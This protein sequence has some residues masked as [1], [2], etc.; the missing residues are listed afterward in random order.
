MKIFAHRG[1][2]GRFPENTM[3]A[4]SEAVKAGADGIELDVHQSKDGKLVIIHDEALGRTT[5][6]E[7]LVNDYP[8]AELCA[9]NAGKTFEDRF[10][11]TPIP[12][13]EEYCDFICKTDIVTNVEIKTNLNCYERIEEDVLKMISRYHLE[14]RVVISSFNWLSVMRMKQLCPAMPCGLLHEGPPMKG[15]GK[16]ASLVKIE[17]YHP[18]FELLS[19]EIV[20]DCHENSI[21]LNV[22]TVNREEQFKKLIAWGASSA[23]TNFP[24]LGLSLLPHA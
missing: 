19:D 17:Y 10:G 16:L 15:I 21:G 12:S 4:F 23:I 24:D 14:D 1:F 11:R 5:G 22:W 9:M 18:G 3:L 6:R 13:F 20:A 8:L 2:S 7:G